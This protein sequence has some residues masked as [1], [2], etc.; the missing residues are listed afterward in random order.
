MTDHRLHAPATLRNREPILETLREILPKS[1]LVLEIA[2]GSGEHIVHFAAH[3]PNLTFQPSDPD[4]D[5]LRSIQAWTEAAGLK[6]VLPP[7]LLDSTQE[8]WPVTA[9]SAM[10]CINMIHIAPWQAARSLL[11]HAGTILPQGGPLYL[12]GPYRRENT[13]WAESNEAFDQG[14]KARNPEWGVRHLET[15]AE[16]AAVSGFGPPDIIDMPANNLGVTFRRC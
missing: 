1:G 11:R 14:L 5:A 16:L 12:Y 15:V 9:A 4:P 13:D 2:S 10:L 6:N 3:L 8:S 7:I